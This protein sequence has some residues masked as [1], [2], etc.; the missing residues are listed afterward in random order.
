MSFP[1]VITHVPRIEEILTDWQAVIG[2]DYLGYRGHVYRMFNFCLALRPC[3]AE[4]QTKL[5]IA[6]GFHDIG[7]W[8][9]HTTDYIPPSIVQLQTYCTTHHL[10][11][12]TEELCLMVEMHHKV[13][14]YRGDRSPLIELFRQGDLVDFSRGTLTCGLPRNYVRQVQAAIPN[15]GFHRFLLRGA[16]DWFTHHPFSPPPFMRW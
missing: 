2:D 4:E 11:A 13:F 8:S 9:D 10:D 6:A 5:A 14:A 15:N 1:E 16:V 12:W 3:S 7:L